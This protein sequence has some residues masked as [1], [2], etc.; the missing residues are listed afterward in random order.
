MTAD[1]NFS[2][3]SVYAEGTVNTLKL[4]ESNIKHIGKH[5]P[6]E[7]AKQASYLSDEQLA[8]KLSKT[9]FFNPN[10]SKEQVTAA[11]EQAYNAL[12][13]KGLTGLQSYEVNGEV[14]K[15][16]IKSDGTFDTAYGLHKLTT[17]FFNK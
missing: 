5:I 16:F 9:S 17:E 12:R 8:N 10:W 3:Y 2:I 15:V 14:I 1:Y 11:T 6:D 13:N 4:S 7:F